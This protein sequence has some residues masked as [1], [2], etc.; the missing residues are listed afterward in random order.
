MGLC[1]HL[2]GGQSLS[3]MVWRGKLE[4]RLV[5]GQGHSRREV[6]LDAVVDVFLF[7]QAGGCRYIKDRQDGGTF[8]RMRHVNATQRMDHLDP[9]SSSSRPVFKLSRNDSQTRP[10]LSSRW[11]CRRGGGGAGLTGV[12]EAETN[13]KTQGDKNLVK[14]APAV[15]ADPRGSTG[16]SAAPARS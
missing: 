13:C 12:R 16:P 7:D 11:R 14:T 10:A 3:I 4:G 8:N 2:W 9:E 1:R 5:V 6:H 15:R